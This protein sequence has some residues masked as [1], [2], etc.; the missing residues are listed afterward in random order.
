M[1]FGDHEVRRGISN[2]P[3]ARVEQAP[4]VHTVGSGSCRDRKKVEPAIEGWIGFRW[5]GGVEAT[6]FRVV[7]RSGQGPEAATPLDGRLRRGESVC[8][9]AEMRVVSSA[10]SGS[11]AISM[12]RSTLAP[13]GSA[14]ERVSPVPI[15]NRA[16]IGRVP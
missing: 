4:K 2:L 11:M 12:E 7:V 1:R 14:I 15:W 9:E 8:L 6:A 3:A 13:A 16:E 10:A 5:I